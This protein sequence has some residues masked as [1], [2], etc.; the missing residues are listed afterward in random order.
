LIPA[1]AAVAGFPPGKLWSLLEMLELQASAFLGAVTQ[2][3]Q[4]IVVIKGIAA[5]NKAS[6]ISKNEREEIIGNHI[7]KLMAELSALGARSAIASA[8]RLND[9]IGSS[10]NLSYEQVSTALEDIESRFADHVND[11]KLLAIN[12]HEARL[13]EPAAKLLSID[14]QPIEDFSLAFPNAAF[15]IEE[16]AKCIALGRHTAAV[17]HDMRALE[18]G[19][20]ALAR[21]LEIPDPMKPAERNWSIIL[22][23]VRDEIDKRWPRAS[24]LPNSVGAKMENLYAHLDAI[25]NPWRNATMHVEAIYA[26]HEAVHITRCTGMFMLELMKHCDEEGRSPDVSPSSARP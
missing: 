15:E 13:F 12:E 9:R 3:R 19:I 14:G 21:F 18:N 25:K 4:L 20:R 26:P 5:E 17:F 10:E 1:H 6:P 24:R 2:L 11:I 8:S 7:S 22:G 23:Q 16:A